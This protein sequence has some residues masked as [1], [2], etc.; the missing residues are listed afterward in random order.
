MKAKRKRHSADFK[1]QVAL[2]AA[3]ELK[4]LAELASQFDLHPNQI[5][6]WKKTLLARGS[7]V[8]KTSTKDVEKEGLIATLYEQLGRTQMELE[9]LKKKYASYRGKPEKP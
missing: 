6:E 8:F 9:W 1:I 4:T 2:E 5:S 7:E 3:K